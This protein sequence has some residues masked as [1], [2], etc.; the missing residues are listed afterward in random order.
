MKR[1]WVRKYGED[2]LRVALRRRR[3]PPQLRPRL[4]RTHSDSI[5]VTL[6]E[7]PLRLLFPLWMEC[8]AEFMVVPSSDRAVPVSGAS[9]RLIHSLRPRK[10]LGSSSV[11]PSYC[12]YNMAL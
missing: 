1:R 11:V 4:Y 2:W 9:F 6:A 8:W 3:P 5:A 7:M 10:W 12:L